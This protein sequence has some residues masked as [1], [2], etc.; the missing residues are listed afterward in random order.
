MPACTIYELTLDKL[1]ILSEPQYPDLS[2]KDNNTGV[3]L[4]DIMKIR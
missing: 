4:S 1:F 3:S 2:D